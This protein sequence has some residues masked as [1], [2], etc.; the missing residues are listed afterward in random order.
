MNNLSIFDEL[1]QALERLIADPEATTATTAGLRTGIAEL[2]EIAPDLRFL[3]RADFKSRLMLEL[4]WE[5]AGRGITTR[6]APAGRSAEVS[7]PDLDLLPTL[8][9]K[10]TGLYPV[11]GINVAASVALHAA[12]LLFIGLG[13]VMVKSTARV[14]QQTANDVTLIDPYVSPAGSSAN[15]GGGTSGGA[16][17]MGATK[18]EAPR[19]TSEQLSPPAVVLQDHN[20]KLPVE[21]T[22]IGPPELNYPKNSQTGDPLS[23]LLSPSNGVGAGGIG[24]AEGNGDGP[25]HGSG[26]GPGSGGGSG[27]SYY[28]VGDGVTAPRAIY[29]PEPEYSDEARAVKHQG[30][31]VLSVVIGPDGHPAHLLVARSLG[32]GLDEQAMEAVRTWRFEPGRKDGHPVAVLI[33]VEVDFHL[34]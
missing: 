23:S 11:R 2:L 8:S 17:K 30:V 3:P 28:T 9:G 15:H 31:V 10:G 21:A 6:P 1:D 24:S 32:M 12:M 7:R 4:E 13:L 18:G 19:F 20:P 22:L 26:H 33:S 5:A 27:G 25:G 34:F 29:S 16:V 14:A